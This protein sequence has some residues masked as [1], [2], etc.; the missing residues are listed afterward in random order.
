MQP[1]LTDK[2]YTQEVISYQ[3]CVP[4]ATGR[5]QDCEYTVCF[6]PSLFL[7][8]IVR[9]GINDQEERLLFYRCSTYRRLQP[10]EHLECVQGVETNTQ[11]RQAGT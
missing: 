10:V 2:N 8:S 5:V 9:W 3:W 1:A 4:C 11:G 6:Y 7:A